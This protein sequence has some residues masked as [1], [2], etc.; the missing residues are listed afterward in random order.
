MI[1]EA[2]RNGPRSG[3]TENSINKYIKNHYCFS[4]DDCSMP[5]T[6]RLP[7]LVQKGVLSKNALYY[8]KVPY[9]ELLNFYQRKP[10][11]E[12]I[13]IEEEEHGRDGYDEYDD[14]E[15]DEYDEEAQSSNDGGGVDGDEWKLESEFRTKLFKLN[16][17]RRILDFEFRE[18]I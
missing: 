7:E 2:I 12:E 10:A 9:Q 1:Y 6:I 17:T 16:E 18:V 14:Y 11:S 8:L 3:C 13:K 5:P 15:F 4:L